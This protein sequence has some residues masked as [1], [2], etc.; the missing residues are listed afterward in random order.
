MSCSQWNLS[1]WGSQKD[2]NQVKL[3]SYSE[4][5]ESDYLDHLKSFEKV[6]KKN[7]SNKIIHLKQSTKRYLSSII[8]KI[9]D[10][11]E[12]FFKRFVETKFFVIKSKVPF[13]FS[14][15]NGKFFFSS[16][17][18][19]KYIKNESMLYCLIVY[20]FIRSEKGIYKKSIII[21]TGVIDTNR[22]LSILRLSSK[23]KIEIHKW[24]FY[25]LK[26]AGIDT[27]TY[28]SWLQVK[29]RNSLDFST[30]LGDIQ[31]ISREEALFKA[32]LIKTEKEGGNKTR[33]HRGSSKRFYSFLNDVKG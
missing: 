18:L 29:N 13:H 19:N 3:V 8:K 32:F 1:K 15:P 28:L 21:P 33:Q 31:S 16:S 6:Y 7:N 14:L 26:R 30:Q 25:L 17:L 23:D 24:A 12:L 20:E 10:N 22:M 11:N 2:D 5:D 9:A 4:F 27:D